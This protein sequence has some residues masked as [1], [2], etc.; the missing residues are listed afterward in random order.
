MIPRRTFVKAKTVGRRAWISFLSPRRNMDSQ[1]GLS[2]RRYRPE[3]AKI[4]ERKR[5]V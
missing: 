3:G 2:Q 4:R 1:P 5:R